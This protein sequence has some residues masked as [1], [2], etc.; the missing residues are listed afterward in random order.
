MDYDA[1]Y[2]KTDHYFG[3]DPDPLLVRFFPLLDRNRRVL[4]IGTGQ[5]R[6]AFYLAKSGF[7]VDAVDSSVEAVKTIAA[8]AKR[9]GLPIRTYR[10]G[11]DS[12]F[13]ETDGYGGILLF[14]LIQTLPWDQIDFLIEMVRVWCAAG[15]LVFITAWNTTD[16]SYEDC[17]T[18]WK[19]IGRNS[20]RE[21]EGEIRTFLSENEIL[22]L[23]AD[24]DVVHHREGLGPLHRHGDDPPQ[25]HGRV[26]AVFKVS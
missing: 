15:G 9:E 14:G 13:P 16:P 19:T 23:F 22:K 25:R 5:G 4:D 11:F 26:E 18:N 17:Q 12:F 7:Q 24:F 1:V 3:A 21:K 10:S 8:T 20:F 6:H 2:R